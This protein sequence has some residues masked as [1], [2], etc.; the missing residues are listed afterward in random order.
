MAQSIISKSWKNQPLTTSLLRAWLGV[1]WIYAGWNKAT[2]PGFL[3]NGSTHYIGAQLTGYL[4]HSP[5]SFLLRRM[6]EHA[7]LVG[8]F[9]MISEFAI[10]FAVLSGIALTLAAVGGAGMS[11][12]LWLSSS[13]S[14]KP[15]FLG[16]DTAY[17]ILWLA[18]IFSIHQKSV[19]A[20]GRSVA[21]RQRVIPDLADRRQVMQLF[22]VGAAAVIASLGGGL[23]KKKVAAPAVG[24]AIVQL[25]A[26]PVGATMNFQ[27]NDGGPAILFRTKA[28]VFAYSALCT[29]QGCTVA[30]SPADH[31]IMCPCHGAQYDPNQAAAVVAGPAP[32][33]LPAIKVA[34]SGNKI[35]QV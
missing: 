34:I 14:V 35:V 24:S 9:V 12:M 15:Y 33:P 30:Y 25:S 10:G 22:A 19:R 11:A 28:G 8:W 3:S 27:A 13:W 16:S 31:L 17:L 29:H 23:L 20:S 32:T 2:D 21:V 5:I 7:T 18:L 6:I 26:F 1:T 4:G